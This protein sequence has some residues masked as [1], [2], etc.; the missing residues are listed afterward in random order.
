[1]TNGT[2]RKSSPLRASE[3]YGRP[4]PCGLTPQGLYHNRG[5]A[6]PDHAAWAVL[7]TRSTSIG[8][9]LVGNPCQHSCACTWPAGSARAPRCRED[10]IIGLRLIFLGLCLNNHSNILFTD[11]SRSL[12]RGTDAATINRRLRRSGS[13]IAAESKP[14]Q[15]QGLEKR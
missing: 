8:A 6:R 7:E 14:T 4:S 11:R 15:R 12:L 13:T 9:F 3:L 5:I 1:M 10:G 2:L